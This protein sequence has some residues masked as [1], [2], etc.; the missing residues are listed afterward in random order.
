M[1]PLVNLSY[2]PTPS[3]HHTALSS[4]PFVYS[5]PSRTDA[6]GIVTVRDT[7]LS[8]RKGN[9]LVRDVF[10]QVRTRIL[11]PSSYPCTVYKRGS[12]TS[13]RTRPR[14]VSYVPS[15]YGPVAGATTKHSVLV[16]L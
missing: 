9:G 1:R 15:L 8:L 2:E 12:R 14:T 10:E 13:D 11:V 3:C 4:P 7:K 16:V 5:P 6:A